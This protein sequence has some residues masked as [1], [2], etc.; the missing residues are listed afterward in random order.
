MSILNQINLTL[1]P[2]EWIQT[3]FKNA[4]EELSNPYYD[5]LTMTDSD[6]NNF[7]NNQIEYLEGIANQTKGQD[8]L[9][10][11]DNY[12]VNNK[13]YDHLKSFI[14]F[15]NFIINNQNTIN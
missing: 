10:V 7:V 2:T 14:I 15:K 6:F 9:A 5:N 11:I 13:Y 3:K 12:L 8:L 4:R 1:N